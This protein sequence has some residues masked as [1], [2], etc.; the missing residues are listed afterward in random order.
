VPHD[1]ALL[2]F[3]ILGGRQIINQKHDIIIL[4]ESLNLEDQRIKDKL[5]QEKNSTRIIDRNLIDLFSYKQ[6][7]SKICSNSELAVRELVSLNR[8]Q[9]VSLTNLILKIQLEQRYLG[10]FFR[11]DRNTIYCISYYSEQR[12]KIYRQDIS[13][14]IQKI[15]YPHLCY[16][17]SLQSKLPNKVIFIVYE[18]QDEGQ[19]FKTVS[20][21]NDYVSKFSIK[22]CG[23][24][25]NLPQS[26]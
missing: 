24:S 3:F 4:D 6:N 25:N 19:D 7:T 15:L 12:N 20:S 23:E 11:E 13:N 21:K 17:L 22:I 10:V 14:Y 1:E 8:S 26:I 9:R 18:K 2:H 16:K 5:T